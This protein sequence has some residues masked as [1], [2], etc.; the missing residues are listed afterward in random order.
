MYFFVLLA[1]TVPKLYTLNKDKVDEVSSMVVAK[2]KELGALAQEQFK[3]K[4]L[5]KIKIPAQ[6]PASAPSA[7]KTE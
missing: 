1:F 3:E 5:S 7:K 4:V 2:G 6:E